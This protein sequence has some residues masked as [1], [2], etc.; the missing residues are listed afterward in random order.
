MVASKRELTVEAHGLRVSVAH[1]QADDEALWEMTRRAFLAAQQCAETTIH[2][3]PIGECDES[4]SSP[5]A[6]AVSTPKF[7]RIRNIAMRVLADGEGH[8]R[9][10]IS[11]AVREAGLDPNPLNKAL[12]GHFER[13]VNED[14]RPCYRDPGISPSDD[15][16]EPE[17]MRQWNEDQLAALGGGNGAR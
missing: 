7:T 16:P 12:E 4:S 6:D 9:R 15:G 10:E 3:T 14:G 8:E 11:K 5:P 2:H 13:Y 17:W 1:Q